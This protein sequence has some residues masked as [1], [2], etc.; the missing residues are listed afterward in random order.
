MFMNTQLTDKK[1]TYF[2]YCRK[3]S[4]SED[5]QVLSLPAQ[6]SELL[7]FA[8]DNKLT[9]VDV[10]EESASAHVIER[11]KFN[12]MLGRMQKG[13]A[14]GLI[15]WDES[16]IARNSFDG[17][18][19]IYMIDLGQIVEIRKPGKTYS[20][21]PDDKSWLAMCFMMSKKESDDKGVNVRRG[22]REKAQQGM[23]VG[24][25]KPGYRFDP[26][27]PQGEKD[28]I[29]VSGTHEIIGKCWKTMLTGKYRVA[30]LLDLINNE[31]GYRSIRHGK[32]GGKPMC[33][34]ELYVMLHDRFYM[35]EFEYPTGS[36]KWHKW[37]GEPM[38]TEEEFMRV[39]ILIGNKFM[40][41]AHHRTFAYTGL[42]KCVCGSQIT[43]EEKWQVI[44]TECK[45]KFSS[46]NH[47]TCPKCNKKI[48]EMLEPTILHYIY[49]HC[50]KKKDKNCKQG[51]IR[52]EE[53][54][55][56]IDQALGSIE[57]N[58]EFKE[59][60]VKYLNELNDQESEDRNTTISSLQ[61]AYDDCVKRLDNLVKLKISSGNTD[62]SLLSDEEF[63]N[64]KEAILVDKRQLE[65]SMGHAGQRIEQWV[66]AAETA[67]DFAIHARYRFATGTLADKREILSTIGSNL[68]LEDKKLWLDLTK[69]FC[70]LK[71]IISKEVT[72]SGK[73][74]PEKRIDMKAQL[75]SS[76]A[77]NP[78]M[79]GW[80]ESDYRPRFWRPL[81]YH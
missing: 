13:E 45:Q 40:P 38:V 42:I 19:V 77:Q 49:Y 67:F 51:S 27:A 78:Y 10:Y 70:F 44:C 35:G 3:S 81:S 75:E 61:R 76:W 56:Q 29:P 41:K 73:F 47:S 15:V 26:L 8:S 18:K 59:W 39:Q 66:E 62:G 58:D 7:R 46:L 79:Q 20:N 54:E 63:R 50:T 69:P 6:K 28:L 65:A 22:L 52:L 72:T 64:Q 31:W 12:E 37:R 9:I 2:V 60:A 32:L 5:K 48:A 1:L 57:I 53:L 43:A 24:A 4:E 25:A 71:D 80:I 17:G 16:R 74:E 14:H 34:S 21:T 36:G 11:K 55:P 30:D 23:Y 33:L 68:V